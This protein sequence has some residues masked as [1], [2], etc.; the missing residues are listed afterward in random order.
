M[1]TGQRRY[2]LCAPRGGLND[3]LCQIEKCRSYA[4]EHR[5]TLVLDTT[6]SGLLGH[7]STYFEFT[8]R[9]VIPA[10]TPDV[11]AELNLLRAEP[12]VVSGRIGVY[13]A[14]YSKT[15]RNH[16]EAETREKVTFDFSADHDA[17]LLVHEQC[18][19]GTDSTAL[20]QHIRLAG[21]M[22]EIAEPI[23]SELPADFVGIHIRNT[24]YQT[25]YEAF[26]GSVQER[27]HG[28]NVL[29]CSDDP[30]VV[31]FCKSR[32]TNSV[33]FTV[34]DTPRIGKPLHRPENH[35][36]DAARFAAAANS[37]VDLLSLGMA[38]EVLFANVTAGHPSGF[39]RLA[40]FLCANKHMVDAMRHRRGTPNSSQS[41]SHPSP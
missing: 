6:R 3:T 33:V 16:V 13:K 27:L 30:S 4:D 28:R 8:S 11:I 22:M 25:D 29:V 2:L 17:P 12:S 32:L 40:S 26:I 21:T 38:S 36:D 15:L 39:S 10:L 19:G 23:L 31:A 34:S 5:R 35:P 18:G 37:I 7:F 1:T 20:F 14:P 41:R 9:D 24:D